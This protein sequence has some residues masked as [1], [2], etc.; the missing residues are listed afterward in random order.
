M[1]LDVDKYCSL[2]FMLNTTKQTAIIMVAVLYIQV[3]E[4]IYG[5]ARV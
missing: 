2:H 1:N 5:T 3:T 4:K